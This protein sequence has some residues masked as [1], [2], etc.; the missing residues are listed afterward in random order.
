MFWAVVTAKIHKMC[1][2]AS[3]AVTGHIP[4]WL[5]QMSACK[6][7]WSVNPGNQQIQVTQHVECK[8]TYHHA[9]HLV[10]LSHVL[11][12]LQARQ[13]APVP[14]PA[15]CLFWLCSAGRYD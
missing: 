14:G 11:M 6:L 12:C 1:D 7:Y 8:A 15:G 13:T 4:A 10:V 2:H 9:A 3:I 5:R